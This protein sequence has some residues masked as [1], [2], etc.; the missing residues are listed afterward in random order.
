LLLLEFAY[1][2]TLLFAG[3]FDL[4]GFLLGFGFIWLLCVVMFAL[5]I[6]WVLVACLCGLIAD[7]FKFE[8]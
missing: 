5:V 3:W 6:L 7:L 8:S 1:L 2:V 4:L